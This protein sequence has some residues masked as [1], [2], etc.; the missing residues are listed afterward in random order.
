VVD[1]DVTY[2]VREALAHTALAHTAD[3]LRN[4][5]APARTGGIQKSNPFLPFDERLFVAEVTEDYLALLNKFN[6]A[7]NHLL[8]VTRTFVEQSTPLGRDDFVAW[9]RCLSEFD[10]LAFYNS[11]PEAGASQPHRHL[12]L[13]PLPLSDAASSF[14]LAARLVS[15]LGEMGTASEL[16]SSG[17]LPY[18]HWLV[19]LSSLPAATSD[20]AAEEMVAQYLRMLGALERRPSASGEYNLLV[21][22]QWMLMIPRKCERY[23]SISLNALAFAGALFVRTPEEL[24]LVRE[25][26]PEAAMRF[27]TCQ[28]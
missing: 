21:T 18:E 7:A 15:S 23:Q 5:P 13:V 11:G 12:Q 14:P 26:G 25:S 19:K 3:A 17:N 8:L 27:V 24:S 16:V 10:G 20:E 2:L 22:K 6:V 1:G 4:K 28:E 9:I